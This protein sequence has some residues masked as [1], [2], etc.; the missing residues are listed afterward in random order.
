[1]QMSRIWQ[2]VK[3]QLYRNLINYKFLA[4]ILFFAVYLFS[5]LSPFRQISQEIGYG[6]N[7]GLFAIALTDVQ[8]KLVF[9][10]GVAILF[11]NLPFKD[12]LQILL[13]QRL[14]KRNWYLVQIIYI[15]M[16][17]I[18]MNAIFFGLFLFILIPN[19]RFE[20]GWG[21]LIRSIDINTINVGDRSILTSI[22]ISDLVIRNY[23]PDMAVFLTLSISVLVTVIIGLI[24]LLFNRIVRNGGMIITYILIFINLF[25]PRAM[26]VNVYFLSPITWISL[27]YT[28]TMNESFL[29]SHAYIYTAS[30]ILIIGFISWILLTTTYRTEINIGD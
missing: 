30:G 8:V 9:F 26:G 5:I 28:S 4:I 1:M 23:S 24:I 2:S 17:S 10:V 12:S 7:Y 3:I 15:V 29:P 13:V 20:N 14:G 6:V 21:T 27:N 19:I 25:S 16:S 22:P 18:I 11:S